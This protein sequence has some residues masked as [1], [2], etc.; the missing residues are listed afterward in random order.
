MLMRHQDNLQMKLGYFICFQPYLR[1]KEAGE[2]KKH[3]LERWI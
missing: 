2:S 3:E 1:Q